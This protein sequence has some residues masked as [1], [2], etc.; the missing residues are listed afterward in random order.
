MYQRLINS[1]LLFLTDESPAASPRLKGTTLH[2]FTPVTQVELVPNTAVKPRKGDV[3]I[4]R[5]A[6]KHVFWSVTCMEE[7]KGFS[8]EVSVSLFICVYKELDG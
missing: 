2:P 6:I 7:Y 1:E 8:F 4:P 3:D 5:D